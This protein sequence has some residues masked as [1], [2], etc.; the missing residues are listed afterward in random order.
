MKKLITV[1]FMLS[2]V[3]MF[4]GCGENGQKTP[5]KSNN[6]NTQQ[7]IQTDKPVLP[8]PE[9]LPAVTENET[10]EDLEVAEEPAINI[11]DE[12]SRYD[13]IVGSENKNADECDTLTDESM[14]QNCKSKI[15]TSLALEKADA[16]YCK[17]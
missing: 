6:E 15:Y 9:D 16:S 4:S 5:D 3:L 17:K 1:I 10:S 14:I 8:E 2:A 11:D 13:E 7:N 12:L